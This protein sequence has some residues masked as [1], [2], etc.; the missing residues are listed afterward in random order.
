FLGSNKLTRSLPAE[1]S[2]SLVNIN[3]SFTASSSRQ[4]SNTLDSEIF[5]TARL[6]AGSL[7]YY[8]L[9][10]ENGNYSVTLQFAELVIDNGITWKSLGR[11]VF[12]IHIQGSLA[13]KNFDIRK[14]ASGES[15]KVVVKKFT[16]LVTENRLEIHLL[17]AGKGTCCVPNQGTYGPSISAVSITPNFVPSV[18][19][20]PPA[21]NKT[22]LVLAIFLPIVFLSLMLLTAGYVI[23]KRRRLQAAQDEELLGGTLGDNRVIA[24]KQLAIKTHQGKRQFVAE[25]AA[26]STAL[27]RNLVKLYECCI[28][29][30]K[31]SL[32][33]EYLENRS[34]DRALFGNKH[35]TWELYESN[36]ELELVDENLKEIDDDEV[37]RVIRIALLCTQISHAERPTMSRVVAMLSGDVEV[38]SVP[39]KPQYML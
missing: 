28:E 1:K 6:S 37:K 4:F 17:W 5:Q 14:E 25:I 15:F 7:R 3:V 30:D 24:V 19:N 22:G 16:A 12:D 9:G 29:G 39:A 18:S 38:C 13:L 2:S 36:R 31:R 26:I 21:K 23:L 33:Y 10:L 27:H 34:L 8:G 35:F 32:V 20:L 11:Q